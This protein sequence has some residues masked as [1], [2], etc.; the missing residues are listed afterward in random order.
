MRYLF[1]LITFLLI[2]AYSFGQPP[3]ENSTPANDVQSDPKKQKEWN[4]KKDKMVKQEK[5]GIEK[6]KKDL[7]KAQSPAVRKR[8]KKNLRKANKFNGQ[9]RKGESPYN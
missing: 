8:M 4:K 6:A 9:K 5:K 3:A 2:S 1:T 7:M